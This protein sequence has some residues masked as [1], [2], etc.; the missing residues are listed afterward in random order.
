MG[1]WALKKVAWAG[2]RGRVR[3]TP[4]RG[5][6]ADATA[7]VNFA[8]GV[9]RFAHGQAHT[10]TPW[11]GFQRLMVSGILRGIETFA[12]QSAWNYPDLVWITLRGLINWTC[13]VML[14][15]YAVL[16]LLQA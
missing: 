1:W 4:N 16:Q 15:V 7:P 11:A 10:N 9:L 5:P 14:P 12:T 6:P 2:G 3:A 13:N 8:L